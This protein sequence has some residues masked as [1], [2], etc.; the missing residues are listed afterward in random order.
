MEEIAVIAACAKNRAIGAN[1]KIPWKIPEETAHFK[2]TTMGGA[3]IF[4]R[5]TFE[6]IGKPLPGR[7]NVVVST[8]KNFDY[9]NAESENSAAEIKT[10][11]SLEKAIALCK[12]AGYEKIFIC[13]GEQI[14]RTALKKNLCGKII[15]SKINENLM[16]KNAEADAFFPELNKNIWKCE[17]NEA[18]ESFSVFYYTRNPQKTISGDL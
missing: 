9:L 14:Y 6:G 11:D 17:K 7:L 16:Q 10:A 12:G 2:S 18:H 3:V 5:K 15:L 4:G 13:G 8:T 1:G